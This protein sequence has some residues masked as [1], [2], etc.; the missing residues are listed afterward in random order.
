[1]CASL[2]VLILEDQPDNVELML[3]ELRQAGFE[4]DWQCVETETDYL[5]RLNGSLDVILADYFLPQFNALRA[6]PFAG[7]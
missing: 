1:M 7:T 6:A 2:R 4:P 3:H 5:A